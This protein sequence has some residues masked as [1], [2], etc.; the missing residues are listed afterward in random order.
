[1]KNYFY[2]L[3][4]LLF[5]FATSCSVD[6]VSDEEFESIKGSWL[7]TSWHINNP[8]DLNN[9]GIATSDFSAGC[10]TDSNIVFNN[11]GRGT[12]FFSSKVEYHTEEENGNITYMVTCATSTELKPSP[13]SYSVDKDII[14]I[15]DE[16]RISQL[17]KE[18]NRLALTIEG[19][20]ITRDINTFEITSKQDVT[21]YFTRP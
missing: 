19:G 9:D 18:N 6:K 16:D 8:V 20:F 1:M 12:I 13:I 11:E 3:L 15:Y 10:F 7:L 4:T 2:L 14:T 5:T 21:Y 17:V